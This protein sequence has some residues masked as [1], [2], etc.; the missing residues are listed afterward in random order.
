[1][2]KLYFGTTNHKRSFFDIKGEKNLIN[3]VLNKDQII[4]VL[5]NIINKDITSVYILENGMTCVINNVQ[6]TLN[7]EFLNL[8]DEFDYYIDVLKT[9]LKK[10][11]EKEN[12][13]KY[14]GQNLKVNRNNK[15][16]SKMIIAGSLVTSIMLT[17]L[18]IG[19]SK[20]I[21]KDISDDKD[22]LA[23]DTLVTDD[24]DEEKD[25]AKESELHED[26][27]S[28]SHGSSNKVTMVPFELDGAKDTIPS[29]EPTDT[30]PTDNAT[31]S[32]EA[33]PTEDV[34]PSDEPTE[35]VQP[36]DDVMISDTI[37]PNLTMGNPTYNLSG[38]DYA[39]AFEFRDSTD[40]GKLQATKDYL[41]YYIEY[42]AKRWGLPVNLIMA[43]ISQERG[44]IEN[45]TVH[46]PCQLTYIYFVGQTFTAPVYDENG[47]TG[48][49][50]TFTVTDESINT[51]EGNIMAGLAFLRKVI[52]NNQSL[53]TGLF[54]YN[55]G[56]PNLIFACQ[57]F[58]VDINDYKGD[59]NSMKAVE[60]IKRYTQ[61][62]YGSYYGDQNY[63]TNIFQYL[64]LDENGEATLTYYLG[65]QEITIKINNTLVKD[66]NMVR[67]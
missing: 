3:V 29:D 54:L 50:D 12:I 31:P 26:K 61:T 7:E 53:L 55:Q 11:I 46:N 56:E 8:S 67:G 27:I 36:S 21:D 17:G 18:G 23:S 39:F 16:A 57:Y 49:Y 40:T 60:L 65:D 24:L 1:M 20:N 37:I 35:E 30:M 14:K 6:I 10:C 52:D 59:Q 47:F 25:I 63:L 48:T 33:Q 13:K 5:N 64:E 66:D 15:Y 32:D 4:E 44:G 38:S 58:G 19:L 42:Y 34:A 51:V 2:R 45:G 9:K 62:V 41:G 22:I 28:I 43:Q